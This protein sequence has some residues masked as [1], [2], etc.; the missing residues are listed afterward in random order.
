[1]AIA[2][3]TYNLEEPDD[4]LEFKQAVASPKMAHALFQLLY[5]TKK[6][7]GY[8][9]E[10]KEMDKYDALELVFERIHDIMREYNINIDDL[11]N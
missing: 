2:K 1:M 5:N 4:L 8:E 7:I 10:G 11:N 3:I 6:G 9:M